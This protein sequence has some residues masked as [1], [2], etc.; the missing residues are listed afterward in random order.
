[1]T[2]IAMHFAHRLRGE[3]GFVL[4]RLALEVVILAIIIV[5]ALI[6]LI[7]PN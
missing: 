4:G 7:V 5:A 1:M 2:D 3:D 6:A